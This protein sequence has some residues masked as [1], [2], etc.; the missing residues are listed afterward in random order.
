[1]NKHI[2]QAIRKAFEAPEQD[3][4]KKAEFLKTLPQPKINMRQ[5]IAVQA[6][7]L[8]KRSFFF[9]ILLLLPALA[10][11]YL[12]NKYT[13]WLVS[14][15]IPFLGLLAVTENSR[16][17]VYKMNEFEMSARFSLRSVI[18]TRMGILGAFDILVICC[19]IPLC[20]IGNDFSLFRTGLYIF[21]PYLMTV[22]AG[23]WITRRFHS[24]E[25]VYDCICAAVLIS[26]TATGLHITSDFIYRASCSIWW[27]A[28]SVFLI[29][30]M[31][32][33]AY[34]TIKQTEEL[35]WNL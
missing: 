19:L 13:L 4:Q 22:D 9:A 1:M 34:F 28:L 31:I 20:R 15:F 29:G 24:K 35:A 2:K 32:Y 21:V 25:A 8:R 6:T 26:G 11:A 33:E 18:L 17:M 5:F 10:G 7:Y 23:L 3:Q 30:R 12:I 14:A 27:F 16:S